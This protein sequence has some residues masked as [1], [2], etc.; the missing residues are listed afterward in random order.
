VTFRYREGYLQAVV[1]R[2]KYDEHEPFCID[3]N[4]VYRL[5]ARWLAAADVDVEA[6]EKKHKPRLEQSWHVPPNFGVTGDTNIVAIVRNVA[7]GGPDESWIG[8]NKIM[9]PFF[10]VVWG[11]DAARVGVCA[12]KK[13]LT[14][15]RLDDFSF[16]RRP[17]M[18]MT[19]ALELNRT[20]DP[21]TT[22]RLFRLPAAQTNLPPPARLARTL[23]LPSP[24]LDRPPTAHLCPGD[25]W[26]RLSA[27]ATET[28]A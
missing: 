28:E 18:V 17:Q 14:E 19:N 24:A 7:T 22:H 10:A 5:A 6:L 20:P 11:S 25:K 16:S 3:T 12:T 2:K 4:E 8:T 1:V 15:L 26:R 9:E 13:E 27:F 23:L 21:P